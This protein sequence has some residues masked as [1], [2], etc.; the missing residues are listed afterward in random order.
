MTRTQGILLAV[1]IAIIIAAY[2]IYQSWFKDD[3]EKCF[4][5]PKSP[6]PDVFG[7][8]YWRAF[9]KLAADIPCSHC[10]GFAEQFMSF[11]HDLVNTKLG[12][13]LYDANNYNY[14]LQSISK[15]NGGQDFYTSF[16]IQN[17]NATSAS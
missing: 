8:A 7:S 2:F 6:D 10:R 5:L 9:H 13:P 1:G 17:P 4:H 16:G 15:I 11:F 3:D 12:K 14:F